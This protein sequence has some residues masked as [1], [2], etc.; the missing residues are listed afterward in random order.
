MAEYLRR[1]EAL[2]T[3]EK[4]AA[5]K[6]KHVVICGVGG[7]GS[8]VCEALARSGIGKLT[9]VDFDVVEESNLNRQLMSNKDNIS[10]DKVIAMKK[11]LEEISD[12]QIETIKTFINEDFILPDCDYVADCIDS[13]KSKFN[14]VKMAHS[15]N[16]P[17]ISS[18][19]TAKRLRPQGLKRTTLD[20]TQNDPL[21]RA[22]RQLVRKENYYKKIDVVFI[23]QAPL[24]CE[25]DE[26]GS[27][28]FAVGSAGLYIAEIIFE[29][30]LEDKYV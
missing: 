2:V 11:H 28:I 15:R 21:A 30:L 27:S 12:C 25:N 5:L 17:I 13:L 23:D 6:Q 19:G 9:L 29:E 26:L 22:F 4:I 20:K 16:I 3:K 14:L 18:L 10:Q 8:F 1:I 24:E 7:V